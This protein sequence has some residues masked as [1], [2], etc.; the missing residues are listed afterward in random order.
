MLTPRTYDSAPHGDGQTQTRSAARPCGCRR[1]TGRRR[2]QM[3]I[4]VASGAI[5]GNASKN[6]G[7][8]ER[9][10]ACPRERRPSSALDAFALR[11][12]HAACPSRPLRRL[13]AKVLNTLWSLTYD[14]IVVA[15]RESFHPAHRCDLQTNLSPVAENGSCTAGCWRRSAVRRRRRHQ[16]RAIRIS[17]TPRSWAAAWRCW[18]PVRHAMQRDW[19]SRRRP[20]R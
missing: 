13:F 20:R 17:A 7:L 16:S 10:C 5:A 11:R 6:A 18:N 14:V 19:T 3:R 9:P 12:R 1:P 2:R 4:A 8:L 15:W